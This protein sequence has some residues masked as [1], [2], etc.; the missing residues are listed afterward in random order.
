MAR[1]RTLAAALLAFVVGA[2]WAAAVPGEG[3]CGLKSTPDTCVIDEDFSVPDSAE[4]LTFV[5][6]KVE[7]R[8]TLTVAFAGVCS[9]DPTLGCASDADC[10]SPP[11]TCRRSARL[12]VQLGEGF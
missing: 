4:P 10:G 5:R 3:L 9:L 8:S 11:D 6:P 12:T 2:R 7:L 1:S